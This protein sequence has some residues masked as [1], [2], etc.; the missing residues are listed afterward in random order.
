[1]KTFVLFT[2]L[3][4]AQ[5]GIANSE[6]PEID[7]SAMLFGEGRQERPCLSFEDARARL[8]QNGRETL[9]AVCKGDTN[10][11]EC[12]ADFFDI[13]RGCENEFFALQDY[14]KER[15]S[16]LLRGEMG[17]LPQDVVRLIDRLKRPPLREKRNEGSLERANEQQIRDRLQQGRKLSPEDAERLIDSFRNRS[18]RRSPIKPSESSESLERNIE[19]MRERIREIMDRRN[20]EIGNTL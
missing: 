8:A 3:F 9:N 6:L 20:M 2:A 11:R 5:L 16:P 14:L 1:M 10:T 17:H 19:R 4:S 13:P 7:R 18:P 15:F 12:I